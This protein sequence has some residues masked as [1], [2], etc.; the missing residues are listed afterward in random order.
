MRLQLPKGDLTILGRC[1]DRLSRTV[2]GSIALIDQ[3]A[4]DLEEKGAVPHDYRPKD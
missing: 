1:E 2:R 4:E 3:S